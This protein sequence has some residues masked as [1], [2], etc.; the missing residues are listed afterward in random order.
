MCIAFCAS[1]KVNLCQSLLW[2]MRRALNFWET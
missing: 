2:G 1:Q